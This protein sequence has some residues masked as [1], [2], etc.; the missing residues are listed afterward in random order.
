MAVSEYER[1][2][3][4]NVLR[5]AEELRQ[6]LESSRNVDNTVN[7]LILKQATS[8]MRD[9]GTVN[10]PLVPAT[11]Q[12]TKKSSTVEVRRSVR[13]MGRAMEEVDGRAPGKGY[14]RRQVV[15]VTRRY[16]YIYVSCVEKIIGLWKV[17][18]PVHAS[19]MPAGLAQ[20]ETLIAGTSL[21]IFT[22]L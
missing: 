1:R 5:K 2:Q 13:N 8:S 22:Q 19:E 11:T 10:V 21:S 4:D 18:A 6:L 15:T 7:R 9:S 14:R 3:N 17:E 16:A 12:R 20:G